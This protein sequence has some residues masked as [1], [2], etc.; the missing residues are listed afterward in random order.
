MTID[1]NSVAT[2]KPSDGDAV[3]MAASRPRKTRRGK[4]RRQERPS[5]DS[6]AAPPVSERPAKKR[7]S[8]QIVIRPRQVPKAPA[9]FTQFIIDD[10]ENC[11][12]YQSF[13]GSPPLRRRRLDSCE[14]DGGP[15]A[16]SV[17]E[18]DDDD[19]EEVVPKSSFPA[20]EHYESLDYGNMV[21]FYEKD[22]EAVYSSARVEEL[23]QIP[24]SEMIEMY[25]ALERRAEELCDQLHHWDPLNC[26]DELQRQLLRLQEE[27][28]A[29]LRLN[30]SLVQASAHD[31]ASS[32][33]LEEEVDQET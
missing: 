25:W 12:L 26:L 3:A 30:A 14:D 31:L 22:F 18:D 28:Q 21:E 19:G 8:G 9:N 7:R 2:A 13:E 24:R 5:D 4:K 11:A 15:E 16:A 32:S 20:G 17:T 1:R 27:N 33:G 10:H 29:L 6:D 23:L